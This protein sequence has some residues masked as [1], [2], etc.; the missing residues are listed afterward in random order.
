MWFSLFWSFMKIGVFTLGGGY[1][2]LPLIEREVIDRHGWVPRE[3]FLELITLAQSAPGPVSLN[4]AVFVGYTKRGFAGAIAAVLGVVVPSFVIILL[5]ATFFSDVKDNRV[6][7]AVFKGIRPAV[8]ALIL[9]PVVGLAKGLNL[10]RAGIAVLVAAAIW[11]LGLS[12]IWFIAIGAAGG[13]AWVMMRN[14][15]STT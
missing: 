14:K 12:P 3:K 2:M 1:A 6:V 10:Y 4:V 9:A 7:E 5:I 11:R 13:I 15:K 8:V